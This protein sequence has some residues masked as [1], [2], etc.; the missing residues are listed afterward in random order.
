MKTWVVAIIENMHF[1]LCLLTVKAQQSEIF[2][3][4]CNLH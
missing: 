3:I 1:Y 2:G 4:K